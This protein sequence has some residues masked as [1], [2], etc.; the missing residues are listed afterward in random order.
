MN[1]THLWNSQTYQL[2]KE[3]VLLARDTADVWSFQT[4][5]KPA[6]QL[7]RSG[8]SCEEMCSE[9]PDDAECLEMCE[10]EFADE[11]AEMEDFA[12]PDQGPPEDA[13]MGAE[14]QSAEMTCNDMCGDDEPE[15][16]NACNACLPNSDMF[17][18]EWYKCMEEMMGTEAGHDHSDEQHEQ[19]HDSD[20][21]P[22]TVAKSDDVAMKEQRRM[23]VK[24][25]QQ[26]DIDEMQAARDLDD[27]NANAGDRLM[28]SVAAPVF[29]NADFFD[30]GGMDEAP[31]AA[32]AAV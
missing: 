2:E 7:Q 8:P 32:A 4:F 30:Y 23:M 19:H 31:A 27:Y 15:C 13:V 25:E 1:T 16:L 17:S 21:H 6:T 12:K 26:Q 11:F 3:A 24:S 29:A 22:D 10:G 20:E 5:A 14:P 9:Y 18:E 28:G